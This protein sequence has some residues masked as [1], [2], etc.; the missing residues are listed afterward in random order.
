MKKITM[1]KMHLFLLILALTQISNGFAQWS[2][3]V[4]GT[5]KNINDLDFLNQ[6]YGVIVGD[7]NVILLTTDGGANWTDINGGAIIGDIYGV[8]VMNIDT[9]IVSIFSSFGSGRVFKTTDGGSS[10]GII[11]GD[12]GLTHRMDLESN[13]SNNNLMVAA[14][15]LTKTTNPLGSSWDTLVTGISATISLDVIKF[16]DGQTGHLSG[17]VSGFS[18]YSAYFYRTKDVNNWYKCD[19]FSMPNSDAFTTMC[20]IDPDTVLM[21]TNTYAGF[22]PSNQNHLI[23]LYDFSLAVVGPS[24]TAYVFSNQTVNATIPAYMNDAYFENGSTGYALGN[25]SIIYKTID[26]G[27]NWSIDYASNNELFRIDFVNGVGYAVGNNGEV[28]KYSPI[29]TNIKEQANNSSIIQVYPNPVANN[30]TIKTSFIIN[31]LTIY[32][33]EGKKVKSILNNN[34]TTLST[35]IKDLPSGNYLLKVDGK[36]GNIQTKQIVKN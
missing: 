31:E 10:W 35:D 8:K 21:F 18:G 2:P 24:D 7:Q 4:S 13:T 25:D 5:S 34:S 1:M 36:N 17:N 33:M 20:F 16:K 11:Y 15:N 22:T 29:T 26:G 19:V 23:K 12:N 28:V 30:I 6:N 14:T 27:I 9:I 32:N 3:L